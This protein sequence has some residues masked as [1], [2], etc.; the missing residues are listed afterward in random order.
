MMQ[1]GTFKRGWLSAITLTVLVALAVTPSRLLAD[2][3]KQGH[4]KQTPLISKVTFTFDNGNPNPVEMDIYGRGFGHSVPPKVVIDGLEQTVTMFTDTHIAI[5]P[6]G[7]FPGAY[8]M[9]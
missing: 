6:S 5:A 1:R 2:D 8:R 7:V 3:D 4:D 9:E